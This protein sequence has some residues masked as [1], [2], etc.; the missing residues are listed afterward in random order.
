MRLIDDDDEAVAGRLRATG[1]AAVLSATVIG[2]TEFARK[3]AT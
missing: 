2:V 1:E 3:L